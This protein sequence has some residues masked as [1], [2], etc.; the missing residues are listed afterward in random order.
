MVFEGSCI[1]LIYPC[2]RIQ[3]GVPN[4]AFSIRVHGDE[5]NVIGTEALEV[6]MLL[7]QSHVDS[8]PHF[9][10]TEVPRLKPSVSSKGM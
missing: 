8:R 7:Y 4:G 2:I 10:E 6:Q 1:D 9:R 3:S 5:N